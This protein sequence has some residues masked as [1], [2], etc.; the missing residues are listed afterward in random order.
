MSRISPTPNSSSSSEYE[1]KD[2]I[3]DSLWPLYNKDSNNNP[4][5]MFPRC[6]DDVNVVDAVRMI[7]KCSTKS[8]KK[9]QKA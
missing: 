4:V 2:R 7:G 3:L 1:Y 5:A 8:Q 6:G 9:V